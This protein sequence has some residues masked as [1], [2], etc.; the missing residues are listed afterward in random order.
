MESIM[1][2]LQN[3]LRNIALA[4]TLVIAGLGSSVNAVE[5]SEKA[6]QHLMA[7]L[8]NAFS[9]QV[10][11]VVTQVNW[12]MEQNIQQSL[13]NLGVTDNAPKTKV[14]VTVKQPEKK[15]VSTK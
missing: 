5:L 2:K 11:E 14:T 1:T 12:D 15:E 8:G 6:K 7:T 9:N 4:S 3:T 13:I 10:S